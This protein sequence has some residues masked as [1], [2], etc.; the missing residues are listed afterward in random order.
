MRWDTEGI[1]I[2]VVQIGSTDTELFDKAL[3]DFPD[4]VVV[5]IGGPPE[6]NLWTAVRTHPIWIAIQVVLS[7]LA[8]FAGSFATAKL[9]AYMRY[10]GRPEFSVPQMCLAFEVV[11]NIRT[12]FANI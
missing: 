1:V 7:G 8:V 5:T 2:P 6:F 9:I 4:Q 10:R 11:A 12:F 3:E